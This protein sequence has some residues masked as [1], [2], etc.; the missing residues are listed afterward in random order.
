METRQLKFIYRVYHHVCDIYFAVDK[1][2]NDLPSTRNRLQSATPTTLP[3][4]SS[5][6]ARSSIPDTV[7]PGYGELARSGFDKVLHYMCEEAPTWLRMDRDCAFL[8]I[9]SG[10]GKCVLHAKGRQQQPQLHSTCS[11]QLRSLTLPSLAAVCV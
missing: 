1:D 3:S 8:D 4:S 10:F 2:L 11:H 6:T 5:T 7:S 9:G